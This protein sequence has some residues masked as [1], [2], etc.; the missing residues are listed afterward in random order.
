MSTQEASQLG[1]D[2]QEGDK[3]KAKRAQGHK[4]VRAGWRQGLLL[5]PTPETQGLLCDEWRSLKVQASDYVCR[6]GCEVKEGA[7]VWGGGKGKWQG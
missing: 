1:E 4:H 5:G 3:K 7:P 2:L 6:Q